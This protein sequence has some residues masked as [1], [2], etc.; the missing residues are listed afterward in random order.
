MTLLTFIHTD[1]GTVTTQ[2]LTFI[3]LERRGTWRRLTD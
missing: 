1:V 2:P 3:A